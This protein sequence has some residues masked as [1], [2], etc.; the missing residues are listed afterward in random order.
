MVLDK[1]SERC[2]GIRQEEFEIFGSNV[3][4]VFNV[5]SLESI[6]K[7]EALTL[8]EDLLDDL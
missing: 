2:K 8:K 4:F 1:L 7:T 6:L 3:V 5:N